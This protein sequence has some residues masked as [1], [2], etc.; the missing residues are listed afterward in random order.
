M[1]IDMLPLPLAETEVD[2]WPA[3]L[4]S[5]AA[6]DL[7]QLP[8]PLADGGRRPAARA[9]GPRA[10]RA[11]GG[12]RGVGTALWE[13]MREELVADGRTSVEAMVD[14]GGAGQA[15]AESL[16]FVNVLPMA[17][18]EQELPE[19]PA[20]V[21]ATPGYAFHT[22]HGLVPDVWAPAAAA[23]HG[24]MQDAP[25]GDVDIRL[26]PWTA[27][28]LHS[29]QQVV[30]DRGGELV[31]VAAVTPEGEVGATRNWPSRTPP[32]R[33]RSSTTRWSPPATA[34]G[35]WAAP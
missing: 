3:V 25:S 34:A 19:R 11:L 30:L 9:D 28:R 16:G 1:K 8:G 20:P 23:A 6:A 31:T 17:W 10:G 27:R 18:Y 22:W 12:G 4:A 2:S 33:G 7:P 24:A 29:V 13:R 15:F 32:A 35:A 5:A 14:L 21:P 26:E